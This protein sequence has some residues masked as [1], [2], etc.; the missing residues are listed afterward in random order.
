MGTVEGLAFKA[1]SPGNRWDS[2]DV[3]DFK[4]DG[5]NGNGDEAGDEAVSV[6]APNATVGGNVD[7]DSGKTE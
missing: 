5:D 7:P 6:A 1:V 2:T 3:D 4:G